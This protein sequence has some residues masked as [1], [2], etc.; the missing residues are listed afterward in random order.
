[1]ANAKGVDVSHW[2]SL[3]DW[4]PDGLSFVVVKASEGLW[5][6]PMHSKHVAK[7]RAAGLVVGAYAFNRDDVDIVAQAKHFASVSKDADIWFIDVEGQY[8][9]SQ[10]QTKLFIDTFRS[11]TG[12][13]IGLYHSASGYFDAGQDYDWV[14]HWG[15]TQPSRSWDFHQYRGSP[16][17]LDQ[18]NGTHEQLLDFVTRLN[19]ENMP[20]LSSYLP[21][22]T[23]TV[24]VGARVRVE[25]TLN[26]AVIRTTTKAEVWT[27]TGWAVGEAYSGS[28]KWLCR[29]ANNRWEYTHEVNVTVQPAAPTCP[30]PTA[31]DCKTFSDAAYAAGKDEGYQ[32][33]LNEGKVIGY[34]VGYDAGYIAGK[35]VG[36]DDGYTSGVTDGYQNGRDDGYE[37]G[38]DAEQARIIAV[39]GLE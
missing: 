39:L 20:T 8:S 15:V 34:D 35:S 37:A 22:Y 6:D 19:G 1:M 26:A 12:K 16:L 13:H 28:T 29:W 2:Q 4:S 25:P 14:A 36:Y 7:G 17:D 30:P 38:V 21:G 9:F 3:S 11:V 33:G 18:F 10:A 32:T 27:I 23:A 31:E 24:G 5:T